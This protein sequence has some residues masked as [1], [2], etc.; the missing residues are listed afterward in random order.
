[1]ALD[2]D[3]GGAETDAY[4]TLAEFKVYAG[5]VGFSL[6]LP[7][8][9]AAEDEDLEQAIRRG[10]ILIDG[11]GIRF[12]GQ[13]VNGDQALC[14]PRANAE[15]RD[16]S[17]IS[18]TVIPKAI[19]DATCWAASYALDNP[20]DINQVLQQHRIVKREKVGYIER[21]YADLEDV[22]SLRRTLTAV[23]DLLADIL[24]DEMNR[25]ETNSPT[26]FLI[27]GRSKD[28]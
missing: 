11:Y 5:D 19:K 17:P 7:S 26:S 24:K 16:G 12:P 4:I 28:D 25:A 20:N 21:E 10:T 6:K 22:T 23:D 9:S 18:S 27:A 13:R 2:S 15:R 3:I 14:W 8:G 1:M